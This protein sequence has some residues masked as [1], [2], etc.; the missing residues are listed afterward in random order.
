VDLGPRESETNNK[1]RDKE[2]VVVGDYDRRDSG[3]EGQRRRGRG[4][5]KNRE[6]E[7]WREGG[8]DGKRWREEGET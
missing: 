8:R 7:T 1:E 4:I 6:E 3:R 2:V 5:E